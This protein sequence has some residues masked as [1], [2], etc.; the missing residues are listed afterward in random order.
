[1]REF[2]V[3]FAKCDSQL[4]LTFECLDTS[5]SARWYELLCEVLTTDPSLREDDRLHDFP[6]S[7]WTE[8]AVIDR[9]NH[10]IDI[11]NSQSLLIPERAVLGGGREQLN[12]LH[13]RFEQLRG[14][15]LTPSPHWQSA[16]HSLRAAINDLNLHIHRLEDILD[17]ATNPVPW[18]HIVVTFND[19]QRRELEPH[20][21][22]MFTTNTQFGEVYINYCE[23]GKALW[24]V[25]FDGDTVVGDDNIRPLRYYS[26][27]MVLKFYDSTQNA[28]LPKFWAWWDANSEHLAKLGFHREDTNLSIG[29]I[30][31][32]RLK[33]HTDR[34]KLINDISSYDRVN[35]VYIP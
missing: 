9:I 32:A 23:V 14:G 33:H 4:T 29:A 5:I 16:D 1:M 34:T 8:P 6:H 28:E 13:L 17:A 11:I 2:S 18:P 35:R 24:N 19:F 20:D 21:Y 26:P 7:S 31:V 22:A 25:Y 10:C 12:Q 15:I 30:P 27:E 3:E